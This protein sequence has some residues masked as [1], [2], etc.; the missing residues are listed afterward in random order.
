[1]KTLIKYFSLFILVLF[2]LWMVINTL[3]YGTPFP[4]VDKKLFEEMYK[5]H[6]DN[7]YIPF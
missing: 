3:L 5:Y 7:P 2:I 4:D 6:R 1:M